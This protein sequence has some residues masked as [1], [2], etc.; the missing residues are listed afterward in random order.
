MPGD[1][2]LS[3]YRVA[4][5]A[6]MLPD[7]SALP[8][9]T[10]HDARGDVLRLIAGAHTTAGVLRL[11]WVVERASPMDTTSTPQFEIQAQTTSADGVAIIARATCQPTRLQPGETIFIWMTTAWSPFGTSLTAVAKPLPNTPLTLS[12][13]R[14]SQALWQGQIGPLK[15]LSAAPGG[16]T[17]APMATTSA[18][19]IYQLPASLTGANAP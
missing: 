18:G 14:G 16:D 9:A 1:E 3:I 13:S 12:V 5:Q 10:W 8:S 4:G 19:G 15:T 2:P 6:A 7:E 11:R 17:L